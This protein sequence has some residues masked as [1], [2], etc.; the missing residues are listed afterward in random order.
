[1]MF[2]DLLKQSGL[3]DKSGDLMGMLTQ[4]L[5]NQGG[6][7]GL[8][9]GFQ[10]QGLGEQAASW[11][12]TGENQPVDANQINGFLGNDFVQQA[13]SKLGI[14]PEMISQAASTL[15]PAIV[16]KL[17]PDGKMP[18]NNDIMSSLPGMLGGL[19]GK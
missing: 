12:G 1:M 16:D 11:V 5:Q 17:T 3:G 2:D 13:A 7:Q 18:E 6:V 15:L 19:L 4:Q 10:K 9:E 8:V 14:S